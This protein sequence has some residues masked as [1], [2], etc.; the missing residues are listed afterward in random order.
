MEPYT[1]HRGRLVMKG[2]PFLKGLG[3]N[4]WGGRWEP[5][6]PSAKYAKT[7]YANEVD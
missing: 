7:F 1:M 4:I 2:L 3:S 5:T 6:F